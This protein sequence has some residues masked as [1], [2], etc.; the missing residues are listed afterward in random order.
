MKPLGAHA[1]RAFVLRRTPYGEADWIVQLLTSA[2]G[3]ISLLARGA[4]KSVKRFGGGVLEPTHLVRFIHRESRQSGGLGVLVEADL[5][6]AFE[7]LREDFDRLSLA[8]EVVDAVRRV[9]QEDD[10]QNQSL[11]D[12][13]GNSLSALSKTGDSLSFRLHFYLRLLHQQGVLEV[14]EWMHPWLRR[15]ILQGQESLVGPSRMQFEIFETLIQ[16]HLRHHL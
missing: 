15:S 3:R 13:L 10:V 5:V 14:E 2:G 4:R 16:A 7:G 11:F 9:A 12:L 6:D 1:G 8:L